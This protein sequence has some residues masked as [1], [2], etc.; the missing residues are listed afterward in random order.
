MGRS[1]RWAAQ[2]GV[3]LL[4]ATVERKG[5]KPEDSE[6]SKPET[7][8]QPIDYLEAI[9]PPDESPESVPGAILR[10]VLDTN[11]WLASGTDGEIGVFAESN[12]VL[13]PIWG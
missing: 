12:L 4:A 13:S 7:P 6:H 2:D 3:E 1:T 11:H 9:A 5:G 10:A 8:E